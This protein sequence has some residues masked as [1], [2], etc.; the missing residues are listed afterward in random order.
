M[1]SPLFV[2][3]GYVIALINQDDQYHQQALQL[4][5]QYEG[6][7]IVT[8]DAIL[9]EIGNALSRIARNEAIA[10][11]QHFQTALEVTLVSLTPELM[12][13]A[14]SL[15]AKHQD[16]TWGLVDCISFVV[17]Q[18]RKISV[19]LA[20]DRHFVQAGFILAVPESR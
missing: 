14:L 6:V 20:F 3:T 2:D 4:A 17:M 12:A 19:A 7:S 18:N 16:K 8:T 15:Y 11:I 13:T 10:I 1:S 5:E 9:L